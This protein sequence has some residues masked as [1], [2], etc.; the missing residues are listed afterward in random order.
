M[1]DSR[2]SLYR[3]II[4]PNSCQTTNRSFSAPVCTC[5]TCEGPQIVGEATVA[6]N[7][8]QELEENCTE[9]ISLEKRINKLNADQSRVFKCMSEYLLHQQKYESG[10]CKCT[11]LQPL[12]MLVSGVGGTGQFLLLETIRAQVATIWKDKQEAHLCAV[13]ASTGLAA[14]NVGGITVHRLFQLPMEHEGKEAEYWGLPR[15]SLKIMKMT[16]LDVKLFI[17]DKVSILASLNL[18]YLH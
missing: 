14:F 15:E 9:E 11:Q 2:I 18:A 3:V 13:A 8:V 17:I 6:M 10:V 16:L 5:P 1:T 12:Q 7:N 4:N